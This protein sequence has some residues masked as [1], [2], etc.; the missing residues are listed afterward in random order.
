MTHWTKLNSMNKKL[1]YVLLLSWTATLTFAQPGTL[2]K[3]YN[4][5]G[6]KEIIFEQNE[7]NDSVACSILQPDGKLLVV[8]N[9]IREYG[10][11]QRTGS[12]LVRLLANGKP[13][14]SFGLEGKLDLD[15]VQKGF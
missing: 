15:K 9:G 6:I 8:L 10:T 2:D 13:D 11:F 4:H 1:L 5:K 7:S 3:S 12:L 14:T